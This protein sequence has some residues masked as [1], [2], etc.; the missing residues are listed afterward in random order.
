DKEAAFLDLMLYDAKKDN[1]ELLEDNLKESELFEKIS[2]TSGL[3]MKEM[4]KDIRMRAESKAFLVEMKRKYKI[5]ELLEAVNTS[6][7]KSKLLLLKEQQIRETG[8]VDYDD[9]LGKWKY[10]VKNSFLPR[11]NRKK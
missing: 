5:P 4:W 11:V 10:W 3:T 1:L 7:A 6:A 8:K 9:I 2:R